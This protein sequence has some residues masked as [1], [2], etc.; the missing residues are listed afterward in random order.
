MHR[1]MA[2]PLANGLH[3]HLARTLQGNSIGIDRTI[4]GKGV[5]QRKDH[6]EQVDIHLREVIRRPC[7]QCLVQN[8]GEDLRIRTCCG[9]TSHERTPDHR[10]ICAG[11]EAFD[12]M[13]GLIELIPQP[14]EL[15]R[16]SDA[17]LQQA[18]ADHEEGRAFF[19][20]IKVAGFIE[21]EALH[22]P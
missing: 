6:A 3:D 5:R 12:V 9:K 7:A 13:A 20:K 1:A 2:S 4:A 18:G 14:A 21:K 8:D 11:V 17:Y 16:T 19:R 15:S 10:G 22:G